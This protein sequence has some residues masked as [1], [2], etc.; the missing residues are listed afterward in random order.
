[1]ITMTDRSVTAHITYRIDPNQIEEFERYGRAWIALV[2]Q[3]GGNHH[4]Y[5]LPSEGSRDTAYALFSFPSL[6]DYE[7]YRI[8][9]ETDPECIA[10]MERARETNCIHHVDRTFLRPVLTP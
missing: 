8:E 7:R 5:F 10:L 9:A 3:F 4:G 1:M 2:N 6:S